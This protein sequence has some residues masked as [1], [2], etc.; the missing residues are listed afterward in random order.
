MKLEIKDE[1]PLR[2]PE[3]WSR[4]LIEH[5]KTQAA[6]KRPLSFYRDAV[7]K[8]LERMGVM[9]VT[10]S[11]ND[12]AKE[13]LDPGVAVW[14]SMKPTAD[15]SWQMG[16]QLDN[17]APSLDEIDSAYRRLVQKHHPDAVQNGSGGDVQ[18][19]HKLTDYRKK[20]RAWVLGQNAQILDN[21]IPCDRFTDAR[22]NLAAVRSAL[23]HFRGLERVGIPAILERVMSSAFKTAL[24]QT[25]SPDSRGVNDVPAAS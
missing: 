19:F 17:P 8:E 25:A 5:R 1:T 21:C 18:M 24:P 23:A 12:T 6:W 3:G 14:F 9:A 10:I 11:R 4:T 20:A 7:I 15:F 22:Q 16:L 13:R 2:W